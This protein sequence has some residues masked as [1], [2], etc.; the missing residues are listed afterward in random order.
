MESEGL[1]VL[2]YFLC[3]ET[4]TLTDLLKKEKEKE[5]NPVRGF[6]INHMDKLRPSRFY[7]YI[8]NRNKRKLLLIEYKFTKTNYV[9]IFE[10]IANSRT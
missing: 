9:T 10:Y 5:R 2:F 7:F 1:L 8:F 6:H 4:F 3:D